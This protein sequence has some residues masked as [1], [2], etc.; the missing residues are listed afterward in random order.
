MNL[1]TTLSKFAFGFIVACCVFGALI[2]WFEDPLNLRAPKDQ[3]LITWFYNHRQSFEKMLQM[4]TEDSQKESY[5]SNSNLEGRLDALRK[6]E[7]RNLLSEIGLGLIVTIDYDNTVRFIF[8]GGGLSAI[9]SGWLKGIVYV[10]GHYEKKGIILQ[11]LDKGAALSP[12]VYLR[13]IEPKWLISY[14]KDE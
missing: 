11:N 13:Q 1:K 2:F 9:S 5:F 8:A 14:Q 3:T 7:Y 6:Q 12:G 10:A 4:V